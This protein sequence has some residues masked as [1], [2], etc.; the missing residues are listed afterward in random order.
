MVDSG[1]VVKS[2]VIVSPRALPDRLFLVAASGLPEFRSAYDALAAI[3]V[4]Q[5]NPTVI[6]EMQKPDNDDF[7]NYNGSNLVSVFRKFSASDMQLVINY[8]KNIVPDVFDVFP[9]SVGG[10]ETLEF[11]VKSR[12]NNISG[13]DQF[14]ASSMS[15]G[16]LRALATL[17]AVF[18]KRPVSSLVG[19]EEPEIALHPAASA[20]LLAAFREASQNTQILVSSHS[21]D[22]LDNPDI[23]PDS[24][25]AVDKQDGIT[26]ISCLDEASQQTLRDKLFTPGELLRLNQLAPSPEVEGVE[27]EELLEVREE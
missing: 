13:Y 7:L 20:I 1:K 6:S 19:I 21:P 24:I 16:T 17:V 14:L 12:I 27:A 4:H 9:S 8:L 5:I 10:V 22:L 25:F 18:Q 23:D 3:R 11:R 2:S 26:R 15:D